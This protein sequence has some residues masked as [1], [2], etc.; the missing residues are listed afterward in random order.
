MLAASG[1]FGAASQALTRAIT[2][3]K[4][5]EALATLKR[6]DDDNEK[7]QRARMEGARLEREKLKRDKD[8]ELAQLKKNLGIDLLEQTWKAIREKREQTRQKLKDAQ[9]SADA[10]KRLKIQS[11]GQ[12]HATLLGTKQTASRMYVYNGVCPRKSPDLT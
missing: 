6:L 1:D 8:N 10:S 4:N 9:R 7:Q 12:I 5:S 3:N 11:N 2:L